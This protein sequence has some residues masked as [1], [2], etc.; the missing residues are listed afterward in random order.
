MIRLEPEDEQKELVASNLY[1]LAQSKFEPGACPR[2][3]YAGD[4]LVGFLMYDIPEPDE[5]PQAPI[6]R[7]MIDKAHQGKGYGRAALELAIAE[8]RRFPR[9]RT[10]SICYVPDNEIARAFYAS[11]GFVEVDIDEDGDVTA[12]L[13]LATRA[14]RPAK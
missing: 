8:I 1:S 9:V 11:L 2:A 5:E 10:V 7:F 14:R 4:S 3:I 13:E 12:E 6:Y